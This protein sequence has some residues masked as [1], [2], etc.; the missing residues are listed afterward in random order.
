MTKKSTDKKIIPWSSPLAFYNLFSSLGWGHFLGNLLVVYPSIGQPAF[1][2]KTKFGLVLVQCGALI[3]VYN[4]L[5][6]IVPSPLLTTLAQVASRLLLVIGIFT[7]LPETPACS[8]LAYITLL[9]AWS[10]TEI[11]RY[12]FYFF[13]LTSE[14]GVPKILIFLRYN[15]FL[16]LYPVGVA[17]ELFII[18]S[19]LPIAETKCSVYYKYFLIF[20]ILTYLPGLPMLYGHMLAQ[21]KKVMKNLFQDASKKTA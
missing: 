9:S 14:N 11:V 15:L 8:S 18:Y 17:S 13:S 1:F 4:S 7:F 12:L 6:R 20:S 19:A 16:V 10:I 2:Q 21:R 5:M 3:E